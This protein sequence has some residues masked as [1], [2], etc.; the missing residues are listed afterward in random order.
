MIRQSIPDAE[1]ILRGLQTRTLGRPLYVYDCVGSTNDVAKT[2]AEQDAPEG[3]VVVAREQTGGRGRL[4]RTW[5]SPPGGLWLSLVLRPQLP[6]TEWPLL[7]FVAS[8]AAAAAL[9]VVA[10]VPVQ[11]K[12]PNDLMLEG[13][14]LG[15]VLVET[16][17]T[18]A[19]TGIGINANVPIDALPRE[20]GAIAT[21]LAE[22]LGRPVD[23]VT[24]THELLREL[25][26]FYTLVAQDRHAV[27]E[28]WRARS[29]TLG[30][31]VRVVGMGGDFDGVAESVD[32]SGALFVRT[33]AG[34]RRVFAGEVSLREHLPPVC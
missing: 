22:C 4:G 34:V 16:G 31:R 28:W 13:R 21:T 18:Y 1:T 3:T 25:E 8:V 23:L 27:M 14:K 7:G 11:L 15:G 5:A 24:L 32:D 26:R 19:I 12:W 2:L 30:R 17:G 6:A 9:E 29:A 20:V 33:R 10:R